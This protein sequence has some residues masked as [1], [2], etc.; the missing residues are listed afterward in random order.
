MS[1]AQANDAGGVL[2]QTLVV[3]GEDEGKTEA[4]IQVAHQVDELCRV[5]RVEIC[6]RLVGQDQRGTMNDG[7]CDGDP[8]AL[9]AGEQVGTLMGAGGETDA[10]KSFANPSCGGLMR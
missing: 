10:F 8:L 4:A 2:E 3:R 6:R 1:V 5:V 7:A 9:A